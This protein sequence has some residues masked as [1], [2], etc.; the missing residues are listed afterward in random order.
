MPRIKELVN[1]LKKGEVVIMPAD[2]IYGLFGLARN[3][4]TVKKIAK[5]K[6]RHFDKPFIVLVASWAQ[7]DEL[8]IK[9]TEREKRFLKNV[10]PGKVS[11]VLPD[12][13]SRFEHLHHNR[14]L[15]VRWPKHKFLTTLL[16]KTGP[17]VSTSTNKADNPPAETITEARVIFGNQID[18]YL[19][20]GRRLKNKPSTLISL[21]NGKIKVL[22]KGALPIKKLKQKLNYDLV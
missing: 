7:L 10:W 16:K 12:K 18:L 19:S 2:T 3:S 21:E 22:R 14:G 6:G 4:Q 13:N 15:A 1:T 20:A 5:L 8:G 11:V 9:I 17:L